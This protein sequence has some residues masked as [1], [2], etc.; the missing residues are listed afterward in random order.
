MS[1]Y[2]RPK[3]DQ[4]SKD[5]IK[6][7][8]K[9]KIK[10]CNTMKISDLD[11]YEKKS[12]PTNE[13]GIFNECIFLESEVDKFKKQIVS[14]AMKSGKRMSINDLDGDPSP[15]IEDPDDPKPKT[16]KV[17]GSQP[18][19]EEIRKRDEEEKKKMKIMI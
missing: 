7:V 13:N 17:Y 14:K 8:I 5:A 3:L 4:A 11:K 15:I 6:D 1:F 2:S 16:I 10:K 12:K 18:T 9:D 19:L